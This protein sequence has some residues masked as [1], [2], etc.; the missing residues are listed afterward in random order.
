MQKNDRYYELLRQQAD[1]VD[2]EL[3]RRQAEDERRSAVQAKENPL[4]RFSTSEL[5][6]ELRRRKTRQFIK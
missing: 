5:K 3:L 6:A 2:Y 4:S 1:E